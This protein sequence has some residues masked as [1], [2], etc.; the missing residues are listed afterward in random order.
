MITTSKSFFASSTIWGGLAAIVAG[1]LKA[2]N[3]DISDLL[4]S[5]VNNWEAVLSFAG[6]VIAIYGRIRATR[7]ISGTAAAQKVST[8]SAIAIG[9]MMVLSF[10]PSANGQDAAPVPTPFAQTAPDTKDVKDVVQPAPTP[11]VINEDTIQQFANSMIAAGSLTLGVYPSYKVDGA[12]GYG[13]AAGYPFGDYFFMGLRLDALAGNWYAASATANAKYQL[14]I[15]AK[16]QPT[17]FATAGVNSPISGAGSKDQSVG[18]ILG[19]GAYIPLWQS[20][21]DHRFTFG[22]FGEGEYWSQYG[23]I[24]IVHAGAWGNYHFGNLSKTGN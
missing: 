21:G 4:P 8:L 14:K 20:P 24:L 18:A 6:G 17:V 5:L 1:A 12:W 7:T 9:T 13:I 2:K 11:V 22:V 16:F 15:S 19:A 23:K 10:S 3:I